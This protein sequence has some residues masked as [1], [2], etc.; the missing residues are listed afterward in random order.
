MTLDDE[1]Y[2]IRYKIQK[3]DLLSTET[4]RMYLM[5]MMMFLCDD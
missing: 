5:M 2:I 1:E 3:I 4:M